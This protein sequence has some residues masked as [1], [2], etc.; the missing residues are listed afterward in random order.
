MSAQA[1]ATIGRIEQSGWQGQFL[2]GLLL[3]AVWSPCVGPTLGGAIS[4]ASTGE[5]LFQAGLIMTAFAFGVGSMVVALAYGARN[6]LTK[7]RATMMRI[8]NAAKPILGATFVFIGVAI[9]MRWHHAVEIWFLDN[10]P[11]WLQD[12]SVIL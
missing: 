1:D 7:R 10:M 8:A 2:G 6:L 12:L 9:L 5:N 3:G 11:Y 4:M